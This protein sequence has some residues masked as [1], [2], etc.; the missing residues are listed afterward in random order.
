MASNSL[1][2]QYLNGTRVI[3]SRVRRSVDGAHI[4]IEGARVHNL[5]NIDVVFPLNCLTVVTGV[6][7]SGKSTLVRKILYPALQIALGG[8]GEKPG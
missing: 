8:Y 5:K 4:S 6:S 2:A 3:E 1:T 7:G